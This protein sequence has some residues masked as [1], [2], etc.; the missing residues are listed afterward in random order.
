[1]TRI[2]CY[3]DVVSPTQR[4]ETGF[5]GPTSARYKL[6]P[7]LFE[8]HLDALAAS[9][10]ALGLLEHHPQ[11][12]VTF[13]DGGASSMDV[14]DALERRGFRGHFFVVTAMLDTPGFLSSEQVRELAARGHEVGSHSHTHPG[15]IERLVAPAT[16]AYE[17]RRS[18][19]LLT[20]LLGAPPRLA[21][22]P[23]G[24]LSRALLEQ[25]TAAGYELLLSAE[26]TTRVRRFGRL[27]VLGRYMMWANSP[28]SRAAA[29]ACGDRVATGRL[30]AQWRVKQAARRVSPEVYERMRR[31]TARVR[32]LDSSSEKAGGS[33]AE[34]P[35]HSSS[36]KAGDG[37]RL[38]LLGQ[39]RGTVQTGGDQAF[40]QGRV[41]AE[42]PHSGGGRARVVGRYEQG[43]IAQ[44]PH[45]SDGGGDGRQATGV[46]LDQDLRQTF[47]S[48]DVQEGMTAPVGV[49][50]AAVEGDVAA[51][52]A[53]IGEPELTQAL[54][55]QA[56]HVSLSAD[57]QTPAG[58]ALAQQRNHLREQQ[59]IL[60]GVESS[61]R[62]QGEDVVV[63]GADRSTPAGL[64]ILGGDQRD[65][66]SE[67]GRRATVAGGEI[68]ADC[69]H[70]V[71]QRE[72][73]PTAL[74][75][76]GGEVQ[77]SV[78]GVAVTDVSREVLPYPQNQTA[79]AEE[80]DQCE[81]DR[82]RVGP[83]RE[84]DVG[85]VERPPHPRQ[86]ARNGA[87]NG[88]DLS[89][90]RVVRQGLKLDRPVELVVGGSGTRVEAAQESQ[91]AELTRQGA[92]EA[93]EGPFGEDGPVAVAVEVVGVDDES[94]GDRSRRAT[95]AAAVSVLIPVLNEGPVLERTVPTMLAQRFEGE[96]EFI[97]AE[98][99]SSDDSRAVLE[100]FAGQDPR[101]RI[102][103]N[104][105]GRTPDGLN[106]ALGH[107]R[108]HY[109]ARM[110][111]HC[112][113]P[114]TY[115]ADGVARLARGDVAW[116]AGPAMPRADGGFSGAV[117]LALCSPLGQGPSRRLVAPG[118]LGQRECDLDTGVFAGVWRRAALE[119]HGGWQPN[120]LRNQDSELAARFLAGGERIVS[121]A[122]MAAE[123]VPRR[124]LPAFVRQYHDYGRYR[125]RTLARHQVAR[126]RS[127]VL[128][129]AL[130]AAIPAALCRSR[131]LHIPARVAL[132]AYASAV[133]FETLRATP[134][135]P[136]RDVTRLPAAFAAMH[137]AFGAG[138]WR[139][140]GE[141][142]LSR[143]ANKLSSLKPR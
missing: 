79:A 35:F 72:Q 109:V 41:V 27:T 143:R 50:Q 59:G 38:T 95:P 138:M 49:E 18:R 29:Y 68:G 71:A 66:G 90:S 32:P 77:Q 88:S 12:A 31:V 15:S 20:E 131:V 104:P 101:V 85:I 83:E 125:A 105:G 108:G 97:F 6:A 39:P 121:L 4:E 16:L 21:A 13:D 87:K 36:E 19:E 120:W 3:H 112:F 28:A 139:G 57:D 22:V 137:L 126:R 24:K 10:R 124:T 110:D 26:P 114:Q 30:R 132:G 127:H 11:V 140:L 23:G 78:L 60:F 17:W 98:G 106:A 33:S 94:H 92:E 123:Y 45:A 43:G 111:A 14:A 9:G 142:W 122:S 53:R 63:V 118:K 55:E 58:V 133:A 119:R 76:P 46:G 25:L 52:V 67:H 51:Q 116:V 7:A 1:M 65:R 48:R 99:A 56:G 80:R 75:R 8:R 82:V 113:Y 42:P 40:S 115:L 107:A 62:Q 34:R 73:P 135:A 134:G 89:Q 69:D 54:A 128:A 130:V 100:R 37:G 81:R 86:R 84:D 2:L 47:G 141:A 136:V 93:Y 102:V 64:N 129:P 91:P 103:D 70:R 61:D 96:L 74:Q 117:A 44:R 5:A